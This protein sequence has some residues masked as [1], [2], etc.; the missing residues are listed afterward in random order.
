MKADARERVRVL[1]AAAEELYRDRAHLTEALVASTG[2]SREGVEFAW[3]RSLERSISEE[4]LEA[5]VASG[6]PTQSLLLVLSANVFVAPVRALACAL[7]RSPR[8][9][10][11]P[12]RREPH[13]VTAL[14]DL[15]P[16]LAVTTVSKQEALMFRGEV[17]VYGRAETI[18]AYRASLPQTSVLTSHGPGFGVAFVSA[19]DD[20]DEAAAKIADDV[21]LFDQRGCLS[22]RMTFVEGSDGRA[23]ELGHLLVAKL[24]AHPVPRGQL[25]TDE[26]AEARTFAR[27]MEVAFDLLEGAS[28]TVAV[29]P[30]SASPMIAPTGRNMY[31]MSVS[32]GQGV[33]LGALAP[34]VTV[35]GA[36]TDVPWRPPGARLS[37]QGSMQSPPLDGPVDRRSA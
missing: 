33:E 16:E 35:V 20:L 7:A 18:D 8:V 9:F 29:A 11:K 15:V 27:T 3:E 25:T 28:A 4:N 34:F 21:V 32:P 30:S 14:L 6:P 1:L 17:H 37:K 24:D 31:V 26:H 19:A 22:P 2:L 36:E 5:L 12:S 23:H 13:L 10:V